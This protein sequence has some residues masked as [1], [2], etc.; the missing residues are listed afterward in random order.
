MFALDFPWWEAHIAEVD[1]DFQGARFSTND[2]PKKYKATYLPPKHFKA[3]GNSGAAA[4]AL[5]IAGDAKRV[6]MLGFDCQMTN[7][8][9][10]WHGN[11]PRG[12]A[13]AR[14]IDRW[15]KLFQ[16]LRDDHPQVEIVNATRQTALTMFTRVKL[17]DELK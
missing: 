15:P 1:K 6:V 16:Q 12:L 13:N 2:L 8:H 3:Y 11:H 5:A 17:E 14:Q 9:A 10:H 4:I 7:G